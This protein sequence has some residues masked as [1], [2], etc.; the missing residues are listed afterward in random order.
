MCVCG[1]FCTI[2]PREANE[3]QVKKNFKSS[4][5]SVAVGTFLYLV[6][7]RPYNRLDES[8]Y[9]AQCA[10][11]AVNGKTNDS[12]PEIRCTSTVAK[13]LNSAHAH[14]EIKLIRMSVYE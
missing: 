10:C 11:A 8:K 9:A 4:Q 1:F 2:Y 12:G 13:S 7:N 14:F 5:A 3:F 6:V